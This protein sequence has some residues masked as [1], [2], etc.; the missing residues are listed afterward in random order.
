MPTPLP[1]QETPSMLL[2]GNKERVKIFISYSGKTQRLDNKENYVRNCI[3]KFLLDKFAKTIKKL[4]CQSE[5]Q[6]KPPQYNLM[7]F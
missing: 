1:W 6:K 7:C 2:K 5:R 4:P 3:K